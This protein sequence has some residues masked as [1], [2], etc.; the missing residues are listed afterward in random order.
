MQRICAKDHESPKCPSVVPFEILHSEGPFEV[1]RFE[2]FGLERPFNMAAMIV[3]TPKC[4]SEGDISRLECTTIFLS[5]AAPAVMRRAHG[6]GRILGARAPLALCL[7][8]QN[9][10]RFAA[11]RMSSIENELDTR[12]CRV[13]CERAFTETNK[14]VTV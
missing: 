5:L 13:P 11:C 12:D 10:P 2:H 8:Q 6:S 3:F 14:S 7:R 9:C 4:P 1:A